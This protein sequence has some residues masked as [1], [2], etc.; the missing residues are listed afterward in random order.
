MIPRDEIR[1]RVIHVRRGDGYREALR[2]GLEK[3]WL[4]RGAVYIGRMHR[5]LGL[6]EHP[7]ANP[8]SI[9]SEGDRAR[10][11]D[12]Y[13]AWLREELKFA[14]RRAS[15]EELWVHLRRGGVLAGWCAPQRCHGEILI[16]ACCELGSPWR[17]DGPD[18]PTSGAL[19]PPPSEW[20]VNDTRE[21]A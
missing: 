11:L 15:L 5:S 8:Y 6:P 9:R 13:R 18:W 16:E 14:P 2:G 10:V 21:T 7:L 20:F 1:R 12:Q 3:Y 4:P 17:E 19:V